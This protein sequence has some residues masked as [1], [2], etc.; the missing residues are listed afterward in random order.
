MDLNKDV[1]ELRSVST[2]ALVMCHAGLACL[3]HG[4]ACSVRQS[5]DNT[6]PARG[7]AGSKAKEVGHAARTTAAGGSTSGDAA[8]SG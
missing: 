3:A 7:K 4:S 5:R 6:S 2:N 8:Y 1:A